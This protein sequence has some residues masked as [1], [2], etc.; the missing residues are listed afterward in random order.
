MSRTLVTGADVQR[1]VAITAEA[2]R[3]APAESWEAQAGPMEC[4]CWDA[5]EHL[6]NGVFSYA[7][8]LAPPVPYLE[9]RPTIL[10]DRPGALARPLVTDREAGP[11][12][13][14]EVLLMVGGLVAAVVD[15]KPAT[16]RSWHIW[17]TADP[18]GFAAMG[19][20]ETLAHAFD[21][22]QGLRIEFEAPA[23]LVAPALA[24][25][26]PEAPA[27]T[28]PWPTLLWATGRGEL[29]GFGRRGPDWTWHAA[30]IE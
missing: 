23:D 12:A 4:S 13:A 3:P 17:G 26:F 5:L 21:L 6:N 16:A 22:T 8:R 1:A 2:L 19:V 29:E 9:G 14:I 18:E 10:W 15:S 30:P 7:L 28:D 27:D 11:E 25:L 20:V 24:R